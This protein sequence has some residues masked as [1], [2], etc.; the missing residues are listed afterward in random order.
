LHSV[1]DKWKQLVGC[2]VHFCTVPAHPFFPPFPFTFCPQLI[3]FGQIGKEGKILK[4]PNL[5]ITAAAAG[6]FIETEV[7]G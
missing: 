2:I 5:A 3:N 1:L 7:K 4:W 6:A